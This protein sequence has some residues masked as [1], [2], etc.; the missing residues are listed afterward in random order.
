LLQNLG[1]THRQVN[2]RFYGLL[3]SIIRYNP[4]G[5]YKMH[6]LIEQVEELFLPELERLASQLRGRF[7]A[8]RFNVWHSPTGALTG[9]QGYDVGVDCV[10]PQ[11]AQDAPNNLALSIELCHLTSRPRLMAGVGW[12][13]P[14]G[15]SE[16]AFR[17]N[18]SKNADWPEAT[19]ETIE[20]LRRTF[21][22]LIRAFECAAQRGVPTPSV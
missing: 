14:S 8:L 18:W 10:F 4:V 13:H 2:E 6:P 20:E 16:A 1:Y 15:R 11:A 9:C 17:E 21:P 7:P 3:S 5:A 19:P 12:G 22:K